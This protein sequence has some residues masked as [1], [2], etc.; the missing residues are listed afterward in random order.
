MSYDNW[1]QE[2]PPG[3]GFLED[4]ECWFCGEP[5]EDHKNFC[6]DYCKKGYI[7]EN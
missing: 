1:K 3:L 4:K 2:T 5:V 7:S 6:S